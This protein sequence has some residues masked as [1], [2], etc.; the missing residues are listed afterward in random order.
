MVDDLLAFTDRV[1]ALLV[2]LEDK[3]LQVLEICA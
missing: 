3:F 2:M 1:G